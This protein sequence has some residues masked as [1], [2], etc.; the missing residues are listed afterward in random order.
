MAAAATGRLL[1]PRVHAHGPSIAKMTEYQ[2]GVCNIGPAEIARRRQAG[3]IGAAASA[4]LLTV[5]AVTHAPRWSR[6][7]VAVP[8]AVSASGYLQARSHFCA[9][10]GSRGVFNFGPLGE[11]ENVQDPGARALDATRARQI[12][13]QSTA[14][15]IGVAA[16][17]VALPG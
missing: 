15:G 13:L 7:L 10:F 9:G 14:I 1:D 11:I 16:V 3:H 8:A 12:G 2:A 6:L 17:A 4:L 5:L